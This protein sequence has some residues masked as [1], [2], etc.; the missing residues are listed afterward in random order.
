MEKLAEYLSSDENEGSTEVLNNDFF[1]LNQYEKSFAE[2]D[3]ESVSVTKAR[4][5]KSKISSKSTIVKNYE[6]EWT[7]GCERVDSKFKHETLLSPMRKIETTINTVNKEPTINTANSGDF[8][9]SNKKYISKRKLV[10]IPQDIEPSSD[11]KHK[12]L[13]RLILE[14][15]DFSKRSSSRS[16]TPT[17]L[18][19]SLKAHS[20]PVSRVQWC[21]PPYSHLFLSASSDHTVQVYDLKQKLL[22]LDHHSGAV[23]DAV[24]SDH[25]IA[26]CA[27]DHKA[28]LCDPSTSWS[29]SVVAM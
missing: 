27:F 24:W 17:K 15:S 23:R 2:E 3:D 21:D 9:N 16:K 10:Q 26:S 12:K 6:K 13:L 18:T 20:A 22:K 5:E 25:L 11:N 1:A 28:L 14:R 7:F 29:I 19:L 4:E 8:D